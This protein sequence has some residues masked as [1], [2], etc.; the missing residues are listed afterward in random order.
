MTIRPISV[1]LAIVHT[2]TIAFLWVLFLYYGP[3]QPT[4]VDLV[5]WAVAGLAAHSVQF[6]VVSFQ[7]QRMRVSV[8]LAITTACLTLFTPP[9]AALLIAVNS[10]SSRDLTGQTEFRKLAFNRS[11]FA[12]CGG[13]GAIV[14]QALHGLFPDLGVPWFIVASLGAAVWHGSLNTLLVA[15][16]VALS[17]ERSIYTVWKSASTTLTHASYITLGA[18]GAS[19]S[20]AYTDVSLLAVALLGIP[21]IAS[22]YGLRNS[23]RVREFYTQV[24]QS[25]ADSL[26]LREHETAGHTQRI[27][28]FSER[29]GRVLGLQGRTLETLYMGGLLH[30]VGKLGMPDRVLQKPTSLT[31]EEWAEARR[32][33]I[34]GARLLEPYEHLRDVGIVVRHHHEKYDGSGYPDGLASDAIP[35]GSRIIAIVDAFDAMYCGRP[36]RAPLSWEEARDEIIRCTGSQFDPKV[37]DAF[38]TINWLQEFDALLSK[39]RSDAH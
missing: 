5:F 9:V 15:C 8:G 4:L 27:A 25:L 26:D 10:L 2:C 23:A 1:Y 33:P 24:V 20:L 21:L 35:I 36:Y 37:V 16:V 7:N 31:E 13:S 19:L 30:D 18:Y 29:L 14:F 17:S 11:M 38:L 28:V 32:H 22:Y 3:G 39:A 34:D 12:L 6:D